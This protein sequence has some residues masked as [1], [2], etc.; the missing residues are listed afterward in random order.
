M[1]KHITKPLIKIHQHELGDL[2]KQQ[3]DTNHQTIPNQHTKK[4]QC[5]SANIS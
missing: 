5:E 1:D 2:I 3:H 4:E